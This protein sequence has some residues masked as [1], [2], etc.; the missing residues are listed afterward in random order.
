MNFPNSLRISL[1]RQTVQFFQP[2]PAGSLRR[3]SYKI[4]LRLISPVR[5][6]MAPSRSADVFTATMPATRRK[7]TAHARRSPSSSKKAR[8]RFINA[9]KRIN[10]S[11]IFKATRT[12][13]IRREIGKTLP[14]SSGFSRR[15]WVWRLRH[16]PTV[17]RGYPGSARARSREQTYLWLEIGLES[18]YDR[19]LAWVNRG[20]D[21]QRI[22]RRR[23]S[24]QR[25]AT[26]RVCTHLI[27][28]FPGESREEMLAT[29]ALFNRLGIDGV[30]LHNLHVIKNTAVGEV[31]SSG[32]SS[33]VEPRAIRRPGARFS[34]TLRSR[35]DRPP[36]LG[37]NLSRN[38]GGAG[39]VGR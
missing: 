4:G 1:A 39:L 7:A 6:A 32:P 5:T 8:K 10:L 36:A 27:L 26:L 38:H 9:T 12:L 35:N 21:A 3:A 31:L 37:G 2:N 24:E 18:M 33:A 22:Y 11:P 13:T 16:G 34:R 29:P 17:W 28:G 20:H 15:G 25:N 14:R 23:R 30:K 19:T